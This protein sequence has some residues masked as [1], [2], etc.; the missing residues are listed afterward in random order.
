MIRLINI[1]TEM[2]LN[3]P[4]SPGKITKRIKYSTD[5]YYYEDKYIGYR[6]SLVDSKF[7]DI[8]IVLNDNDITDWNNNKVYRPSIDW[9]INYMKEYLYISNTSDNEIYLSFIIFL[10]RK[11][12]PLYN[13]EVF[14]VDN[15]LMLIGKI[16]VE[17]LDKYVNEDLTEM[18]LNVP[19]HDKDRL[20]SDKINYKNAFN[21]DWESGLQ[22]DVL[23]PAEYHNANVYGEYDDFTDTFIVA[24][25]SDGF[26]DFMEAVY[27][28]S[29]EDD[30]WS[31]ADGKI[32]KVMGE[33]FKDEITKAIEELLQAKVEFTIYY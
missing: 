20:Y 6:N 1:L 22:E 16:P 10:K 19:I 23:D 30:H 29:D 26:N 21:Y 17:E 27:K 12:I 11:N 8:S 2:R 32:Y 9:V 13:I 25:G 5:T 7:V 18:R 4:F 31:D 24:L 28:G 3:V 14:E 15:I 33:L